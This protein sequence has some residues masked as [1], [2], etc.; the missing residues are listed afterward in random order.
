MAREGRR[1]GGRG[2]T[3]RGAS[4]RPAGSQASTIRLRRVYEE[5]SADD[6]TRILVDRLWPRGL[7]KQAA[8][9]DEWVKSVAPSTE[10]RRWYGHDP[11]K[12]DEFASRYQAELR[13]P[14]RAEA[15]AQIE[16][17][18][19]RQTVTLL[20]ATK[21]AGHSE[22]AVLADLLRHQAAGRRP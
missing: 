21:D 18:A 17:A 11:A 3:R 1:G 14:E 5:P 10:L 15:L 8:A 20:T 2:P 13:E 7:S 9:V 12:F 6:G 16:D 19:S 22:A 4:K